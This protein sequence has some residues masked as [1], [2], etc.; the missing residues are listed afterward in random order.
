[1]P[2]QMK[3]LSYLKISCKSKLAETKKSTSDQKQTETTPQSSS[4]E[5]P[6]RTEVS[7]KH[8]SQ[9]SIY[10]SQSLHVIP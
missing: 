7:Q 2:L 3:S 6:A 8:I 10:S 5:K 1:M 9:K 4:S